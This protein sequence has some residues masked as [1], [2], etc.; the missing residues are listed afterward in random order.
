MAFTC[1]VQIH[2]I[3]FKVSL[4]YGIIVRK[5]ASAALM[6]IDKHIDIFTV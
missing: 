3:L 1:S 4:Y 5:V 2:Y 6:L